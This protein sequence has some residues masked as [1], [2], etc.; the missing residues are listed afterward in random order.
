MHRPFTLAPFAFV[1]VIACNKTEGAAPAG[2]GTAATS[3]TAAP[4]STSAATVASAA[5]TNAPAPKKLDA[6]GCDPG[7]S[8]EPS[9]KGKSVS[10]DE[11]KFTLLDARVDTIDNPLEKGKK[12]LLVKLEVE[13]ISQRDDVSLSMADV[14]VSR[15][16]AAPAR[17]ESKLFLANDFFYT[18]SKIC[19]DLSADV[20][21]GTFPR[22]AKVIGY[23]VRTLGDEP[24]KSLWI[25]FKYLSPESATTGKAFTVAGTLQI[26]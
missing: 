7:T 9:A 25:G 3:A 12:V 24:Y 6:T 8:L 1:A 5:A 18:R 26:K 11:L 15:D 14:E 17:N 21:K 2:S 20:K 10:T 23:F 19:V 22:G 4:S 13:N 16:K